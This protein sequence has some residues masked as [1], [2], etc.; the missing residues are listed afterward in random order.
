MTEEL[1]QKYIDGTCGIKER[2]EVEEWLDTSSDTEK[3]IFFRGRW[4]SADE[5]F[6]QSSTVKLWESLYEQIVIKQDV[7]IRRM[8]SLSVTKWIAAACVFMVIASLYMFTYKGNTIEHK[9]KYQLVNK[10]PEIKGDKLVTIVN[11][12]SEPQKISLPD[13]SKVV[14]YKNSILQ[15]SIYP[16]S[17]S[18]TLYLSGRAEF[19]VAKNK[20]KPFTV[21]SDEIATTAVG[22]RFEVNNG[23]NSGKILVKL[24]EGVVSIRS[25]KRE[26]SGW[27]N[28]HLLHAGEE[29]L[30]ERGV[31]SSRLFDQPDNQKINIGKTEVRSIGK[32]LVFLH[33]PL[34]K[35]FEQMENLYQIKIQYQSDD[36]KDMFLTSTINKD[37]EP[38]S[39]LKAIVQM[40]ELSV[41]K[42]EDAFIIKKIVHEK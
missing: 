3:E 9:E 32:E 13:G 25:T 31:A 7:K 26:L 21:Y 17:V 41:V 15:Y 39:L 19:S 10:A 28:N 8:H 30:C 34:I 12:D 11:N 24:M 20:K 33:T 37:D 1:F 6:S 42:T 36:L 27:I 16:E 38:G 35:V 22:T 23:K 40:N 2:L 5:I 18:R 14:L 29:F 4:E